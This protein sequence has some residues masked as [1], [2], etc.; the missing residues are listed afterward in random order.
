M[1]KPT[2]GPARLRSPTTLVLALIVVVLV[3]ALI[4]VTLVLALIVVVLV[5]ALIGVNLV[6]AL[7]GV[8]LVLALIVVVLVPALIVVTLVLALIGVA[9]VLT[10]IGVT[11]MIP[12][13]TA[14]RSA[15]VAG[16]ALAPG[17]TVR[18]C[19]RRRGQSDERMLRRALHGRR[20][21]RDRLRTIVRARCAECHQ[22]GRGNCHRDGARRSDELRRVAKHVRKVRSDEIRVRG[23]HG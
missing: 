22:K 6:L 21:N 1:R 8:A 19:S 12:G 7:I 13:L 15:S 11:T 10:L 23:Q 9:L 2:L 14:V 17:G 5:P 18:G 4:G 16:L 20:G 3:P